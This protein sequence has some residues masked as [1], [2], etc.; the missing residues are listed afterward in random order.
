MK[1]KTHTSL[2]NGLA[3]NKKVI[4][5]FKTLEKYKYKLIK[6]DITEF[7][8]KVYENLLIEPLYLQQNQNNLI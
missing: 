6:Y 8:A 1:K 3:K 2:N 5:C 7:S 4:R